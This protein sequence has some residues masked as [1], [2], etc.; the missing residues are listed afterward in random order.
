[1]DSLAVLAVFVTNQKDER[2]RGANMGLPVVD[3]EFSVQYERLSFP[4]DVLLS[5]SPLIVKH[6][7]I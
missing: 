5:D 2:A 6:L 4:S 1:M 3:I 7:S